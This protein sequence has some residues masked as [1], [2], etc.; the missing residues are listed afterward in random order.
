MAKA[1]FGAVSKQRSGRYRADYQDPRYPAARGRAY[2]ISAPHTFSTKSAA[3]AWLS[4][5]S[6]QIQTGEW[7]S[8]EQLAAEKEAAARQAEQDG[9]TF[10][11]FCE[12][13]LEIHKTRWGTETYRKYRSNYD[14]WLKPHW[15]NVPIR[16]ITTASVSAWLATL[17]LSGAGYKNPISFFSSVLNAAHQDFELLPNNPAALPI[18]KLGKAGKGIGVK[19]KR[20]EA[21]PLTMNELIA[22]ADE[23]TPKDLRLWVLLG[24]LLGLRAGELRGLRRSSFDFKRHEVAIT[25]AATGVGKYLDQ[26]ARPKTATSF[27]VLPIPPALE[28]EIKKHL[29]VY[30]AFGRRGLL[31]PSPRNP[32][33]PRDVT[34]AGQAMRR[35]CKRLGIE[36][37]TSHDLRHSAASLLAEAR[38]PE[39]TVKSILGHSESGI[40]R[41]Y[42]HAFQEQTAKALTGLDNAFEA[43]AAS[44]RDNVITLPNRKGA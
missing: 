28:S 35:A 34:G 37:R 22:L 3:R 17:D 9:V 16:S 32:E 41:R 10:G 6:N 38:V 33:R 8:P 43:V 19:S 31:F 14:C 4:K 25:A 1:S 40:T 18:K 44:G 5:V 15:K 2:R 30:A 7:K 24:G 11:Q 12:Q 36:E 39:I 13:F 42:V 26:N 29:E 21:T 27:R 23:I 20:H